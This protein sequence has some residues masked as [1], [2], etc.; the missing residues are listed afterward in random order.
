MSFLLL[1]LNRGKSLELFASNVHQKPDCNTVERGYQLARLGYKSCVICALRRIP[2]HT[3]SGIRCA[4][5]E[6][7]CWESPS[8][9]LMAVACSERGQSESVH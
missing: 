1:A 2:S 9:T 4:G 6:A 5:I 3:I 8:V 7:N